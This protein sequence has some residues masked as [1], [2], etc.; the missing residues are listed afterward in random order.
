MLKTGG[1]MSEDR[2]VNR[3][4]SDIRPLATGFGEEMR[5][6]RRQHTGRTFFAVPEELDT[7]MTPASVFQ[8][9][10]GGD[11]AAGSPTATLLRL[12]PSR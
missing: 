7:G 8:I 9:Q 12:H 1:R 2:R 4:S 10:K 5:R 11:P 3:L 6:R